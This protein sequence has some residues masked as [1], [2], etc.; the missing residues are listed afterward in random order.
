[1]RKRVQQ[2]EDGL[3]S[4][5]VDDM[6]PRVLVPVNQQHLPTQKEGQQRG[7]NAGECESLSPLALSR[8]AEGGG[9]GE[10]AGVQ[11]DTAS[12]SARESAPQATNYCSS[13]SCCA[14]KHARHRL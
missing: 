8:G 4:A 9:G 14:G 1:M 3:V 13:R 12:R 11:G 5:G 10:G 7:K 6:V 2:F